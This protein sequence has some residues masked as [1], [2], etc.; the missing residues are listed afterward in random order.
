MSVPAAVPPRDNFQSKFPTTE[1]GSLH[2]G[3]NDRAL[4]HAAN[5]LSSISRTERKNIHFIV[6]VDSN[7]PHIIKNIQVVRANW[8]SWIVTVISKF[9]EGKSEGK[10][11]HF[12]K[13]AAIHDLSSY[14]DELSKEYE[15]LAKKNPIESE[16]ARH[17]LAVD[18]DFNRTANRIHT[19]MLAFQPSEKASIGVKY[20]QFC[21]K[22]D[23]AIAHIKIQNNARL[24][25][26]GE[27]GQ[28]EIIEIMQERDRLHQLVKDKP[29][30]WEPVIKQTDQDLQ[31]HEFN[32]NILKLASEGK[33]DIDL[34]VRHAHSNDPL[35]AKLEN[36]KKILTYSTDLD[37]LGNPKTDRLAYIEAGI[38]F[39]EGYYALDEETY[40]LSGL[41]KKFTALG[42]FKKANTY[43]EDMTVE[44]QSL[45]TEDVAAFQQKYQAY[46]GVI[47]KLN[48]IRE[49]IKNKGLVDFK[50]KL[51]D[52][53][54]IIESN[55]KEKRGEQ[56]LALA[57]R[58]EKKI[59]SLSRKIEGLEET[60]ARL[61]QIVDDEHERERLHQ[62]RLEQIRTGKP[63]DVA[64]LLTW[65]TDDQSL[66]TDEKAL[67]LALQELVR[68]IRM[69]AAETDSLQ[70]GRER[71]KRHL[72]DAGL[73]EIPAGT[74]ALAYLHSSEVNHKILFLLQKAAHRAHKA[75]E[76]SISLAEKAK[77]ATL[78]VETSKGG[79]IG[80]KIEELHLIDQ[81]V[82]KELMNILGQSGDPSSIDRDVIVRLIVELDEQKAK[83]AIRQLVKAL[84]DHPKLKEQIQ[85]ILEES[86]G[87]T[88]S[89]FYDE[90]RKHQF[91]LGRIVNH[92]IE[93]RDSLAA[94]VQQFKALKHPDFYQT[95]ATVLK[96]ALEPIRKRYGFKHPIILIKDIEAKRDQYISEKN[97][98]GMRLLLE[99]ED[100]ILELVAAYKYRLSLEGKAQRFEKSAIDAK[101]VAEGLNG[102]C[103]AIDLLTET[104]QSYSLGES[105]TRSKDK[106]AAELREVKEKKA[107]REERKRFIEERKS[108]LAEYQKTQVDL[109]AA[110][111]MSGLMAHLAK[112]NT[113]MTEK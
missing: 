21:T 85:E 77:T 66:R 43:I 95:E 62:E 44:I 22:H 11:Y 42:F 32:K 79:E 3:V 107:T 105:A 4:H 2:F 60:Q 59:A 76:E 57:G 111:A 88:G 72:I 37:I 6:E 58:Y 8:A 26:E 40:E 87:N 5:Q 64:A 25:Y 100:K 50:E 18:K 78:A 101:I 89:L 38:H 1:D 17:I 63:F 31:T 81:I 102:L 27:G 92:M 48:A 55:L 53:T 61:E 90:K 12:G 73:P 24:L 84:K 68:E 33:I 7:N 65:P 9:F 113:I 75:E 69:T 91:A 47:D 80:R 34:I 51:S 106:S 103:E 13:G 93:R 30:V 70:A 52:A 35:K 99:E 16:E 36:I 56:L 10:T 97:T 112:F 15:H 54:A 74:T 41:H 108:A 28:E 83:S 82:I 29:E 71:L 104:A 96:Q 20:R 49:S 98:E 110:A 46:V 94:D 109:T 39:I 14:M 86:Y 67:L 19:I 45:E 23:S